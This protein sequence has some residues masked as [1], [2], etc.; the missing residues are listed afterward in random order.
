MP[1]DQQVS[2][3]EYLPAVR[4][5]LTAEVPVARFTWFKTGGPA[6]VLFRP[7]DEV[8]LA[9]FL[10]G[11]PSDVSIT[12]IGNASNLLVRDGGIDG[13]VIKLGR[14][15]RGIRVDGLNVVV[16]A[17]AADL[18]VARRPRDAG[19]T[20]LEFLAGV[21]GTLGGGV[22][23]NAGAYG[24]EISDVFVEAQVLGRDG[25]TRTLGWDDI[26]FS[27]RHSALGEGDI[28]VST[29]LRGQA[30]DT[31]KIAGLIEEIQRERETTQPVRTLTG[32]STFKNPEDHK[33][34]ELIDAAGCRGLRR[35]AAVV[36]QQH[37]NFLINEGGASAAD[38]EGLGEE[39]RRRV[40]AHSGIILE[41]EIR[42]IGKPV[43]TAP[44]EVTS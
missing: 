9:C 33:A 3:I 15:F 11:T 8:D 1:D 37:C 27:Y 22:L 7:A 4:G 43:R 6:E 20:G 10:A 21:P 44:E 19:L 25:T 29:H 42:G 32:G 36:S 2:L 5:E 34:W 17:A 28:I 23:M 24:A 38:L 30:G 12:V 35:G 26:G 18:N 40:Q 41:W 31:A 39:V 13:V 14:A 16:G